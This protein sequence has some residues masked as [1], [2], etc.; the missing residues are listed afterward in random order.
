MNKTETI[1]AR[2][3]PHKKQ[4]LELLAEELG[5]SVSYLMVYGAL[6]KGRKLYRLMRMRDRDS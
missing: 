1:K 2:T 3:T 6:E 5:V 4:E